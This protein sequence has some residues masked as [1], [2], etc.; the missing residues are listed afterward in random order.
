MVL[1]RHGVEFPQQYQTLTP[2]KSVAT[3]NE[4]KTTRYTERIS[5]S[6]GELHSWVCTALHLF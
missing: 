3:A 2:T 5:Q 6:E 4:V 1:A